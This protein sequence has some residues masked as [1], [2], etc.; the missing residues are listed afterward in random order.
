MTQDEKKAQFMDQHET[1]I[2]EKTL[3]LSSLKK[4][5]T[6]VFVSENFSIQS[7]KFISKRFQERSFSLLDD[8]KE[9]PHFFIYYEVL[10]TCDLTK[11]RIKKQIFLPK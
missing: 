6:Q 3:S 11:W 7:I 4:G 10:W 9:G 5:F 8:F 1:T 2:I